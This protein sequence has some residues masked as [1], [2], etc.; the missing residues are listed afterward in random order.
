MLSLVI[1]STLDVSEGKP[2][3]PTMAGMVVQD[4]SEIAE[5]AGNHQEELRT[6]PR[7]LREI[8]KLVEEEYAKLDLTG[9]SSERMIVLR[10]T[11]LLIKYTRQAVNFGRY[12]E[13]IL[14]PLTIYGKTTRV[15]AKA[16]LK[17]AAKNARHSS[18]VG[19]GTNIRFGTILEA[20]KE[21]VASSILSPSFVSLNLCRIIDWLEVVSRWSEWTDGGIPSPSLPHPVS[22]LRTHTF[23]AEQSESHSDLFLAL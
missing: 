6:A 19:G 13:R 20:N 4:G 17:H 18:M 21:N 23:S 11:A 22:I 16:L 9:V 14:G 8:K 3:D 12:H 7:T 10:R 2:V 5:P 15:G 1:S